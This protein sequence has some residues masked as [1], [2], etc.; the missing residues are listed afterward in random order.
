VITVLVNA[1]LNVMLVRVLGYRGLAL[2]TSIAALFNA[3][4]LLT[5]LRH[6]LGG[7]QERQILSSFLRVTLASAAMG[8]AAYV[9]SNVLEARLPGNSLPLQIL[10]LGGTIG[11]SVVVLAVASWLLRIREFS[12]GVTLVT[13]RIGRRSR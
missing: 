6:H 10:R 4:T 5:L 3:V 2:G 8:I 9:V 11:V 13:R 1:G 7:L 12:G